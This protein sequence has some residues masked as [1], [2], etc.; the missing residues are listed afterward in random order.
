MRNWI[1]I[2]G[3]C[4]LASVCAQAQ[5]AR[6]SGT[7]TDLS[8]GSVR[9]S[10]VLMRNTATQIEVR[11]VTNESG[12]FLLPPVPPGVYEIEASSQG[13]ATGRLTGLTLEV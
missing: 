8:Q 2:L 10:Q 5:S 4:L 3:V 1:A 9:G 6:V 13:F 7:V 11:T 12:G